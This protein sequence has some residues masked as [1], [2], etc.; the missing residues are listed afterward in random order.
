MKVNGRT[1]VLFILSILTIGTL[2]FSEVSFQIIINIGNA[3]PKDLP[4]YSVLLYAGESHVPIFIDG[5][6]AGE[7]N[8]F[9][10]LAVTF[11]GGGQHIAWAKSSDWYRSYE[12][13]IFFVEK[14]PKIVYLTPTLRG[15]L[16]IFSNKYPVYVYLKDS[17]LLG[18][19]EKDSEPLIV[20]QGNYDLI[21]W[22]PGYENIKKNVNIQ[23]KQENPIWLEFVESPFNVE[24]RIVPETFSPNGDW[25][26]DTT[27]IKIYSSKEA[28]GTIQIKD[29][30]GKIVYNEAIHVKPGLTEITWNGSGASDGTYTASVLLYDGIETITKEAEVTID[31]SKY[32]YE[33]EIILSITGAFLALLG[34][35]IYQDVTSN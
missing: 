10:Q 8:V 28:T 2:A 7:T 18:T 29:F 26:D 21:F 14:E 25:T 35:L 19:V 27:I 13:V 31:T 23:S 3:V 24:L 32:T 16:T 17:V 11:T 33:K 5:Q 34:Y 6:Y 12:Q 15:K 1:I 9:G 4:E 30:S 20:P 22:V